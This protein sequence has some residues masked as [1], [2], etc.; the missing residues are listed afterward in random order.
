MTGLA[1]PLSIVC[2]LTVSLAAALLAGRRRRARSAL[3]SIPAGMRTLASNV[4]SISA[5]GAGLAPPPARGSLRR[6]VTLTAL[7]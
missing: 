2:L 6:T 7:R 3:A 4:R 5:L 1:L